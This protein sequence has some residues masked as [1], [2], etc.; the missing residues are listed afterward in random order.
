MDR[1]DNVTVTPT[2]M[3]QRLGDPKSM[4]LRRTD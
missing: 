4:E 1:H 2:D 3:T